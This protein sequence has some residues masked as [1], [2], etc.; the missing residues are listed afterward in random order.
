MQ[1]DEPEDPTE[2]ANWL[3][4]PEEGHFNLTLRL[5]WPKKQVREATWTPPAVK[6]ME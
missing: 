3:P 6:K 2:K 1:Q 4:T 5:Y